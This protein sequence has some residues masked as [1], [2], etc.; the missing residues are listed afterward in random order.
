VDERYQQNSDIFKA[1]C[2]EYRLQILELLQT[3]EKCACVIQEH[4]K[5]SQSNLSHH[6]KILC[7]SVIVSSQQEGKW[8]HYSISPEGSQQAMKLLS[9]LTTVSQDP[10]KLLIEYLYLDLSTCDRCIGTD[11]VLEEVVEALIPTLKLAGYS[12]DYK[13][14]EMTT[15]ELATQYR[16]VSSPST[17]VNGQEICSSVAESSCGCCSDISG[18]DVDCRVFEYE[19]ASYEVPPKAMLT[20]AILR[21][22]FNKDTDCGEKSG[23]FELIDNLKRFYDGKKKLS[24][25]CNC[26][27]DC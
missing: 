12:V 14:V 18:T 8:M 21:V 1:F 4:I 13:K 17:R 25:G 10:K 9:D 3:G 23:D 15:A 26:G 11:T 22:A 7:N 5:I 27:C 24:S 2:N 20:E 6:M 16:F 19:G